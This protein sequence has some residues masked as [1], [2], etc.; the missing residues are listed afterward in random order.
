[1]SNAEEVEN[2]LKHAANLAV[3]WRQGALPYT[4]TPPIAETAMVLADEVDRL[5]E[6]MRR[7]LPTIESRCTDYAAEYR[8]ACLANHRI[9]HTE[10]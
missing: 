2:A 10:K 6:L 7:A 4:P 3:V 9:G 8:A 5:R 1:M